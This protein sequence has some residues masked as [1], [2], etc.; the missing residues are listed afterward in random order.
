MFRYNLL[1]APLT[2]LHRVSLECFKGL[3][4]NKVTFVMKAALKECFR[5]SWTCDGVLETVQCA[6]VQGV[7]MD[8]MTRETFFTICN[9][10]ASVMIIP[11]HGFMVALRFKNDFDFYQIIDDTWEL[12]QSRSC[13]L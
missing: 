8:G 1:T 9:H 10:F 2:T 7:L 12:G 6:M 11:T 3:H 13:G 4:C 5:H